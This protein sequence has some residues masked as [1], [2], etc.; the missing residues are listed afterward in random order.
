MKNVDT[1]KVLSMVGSG[2]KIHDSINRGKY[3]R[4]H[5]YSQHKKLTVKLTLFL[6][7]FTMTIPQVECD[8][9]AGADSDRFGVFMTDVKK[10]YVGITFAFYCSNYQ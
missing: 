1:L 3:I 7:S 6:H 2:Y 4:T 10:Y 9:S 5:V 8:L